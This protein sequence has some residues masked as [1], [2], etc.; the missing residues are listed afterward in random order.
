MPKDSTQPQLTPPLKIAVLV[1]G[2]LALLGLATSMAVGMVR[3]QAAAS[4]YLSGLSVWNQSQIGA[5][6]HLSRY[7]EQGLPDDL[8]RAREY[9]QVP[10]SD[11]QGRLKLEASSPEEV[12]VAEF[13]R[14]A[15]HPDDARLM[16]WL[17]RDFGD[18]GQL[19]HAFSVWRDSDPYILELDRIANDLEGYWQAAPN[20]Q[21]L[22]QLK[23]DLYTNNIMLQ[24]LASQFRQVMSNTNRWLTDTLTLA[25]LVFFIVFAILASVLIWRLV[26]LLQGTQEKFQ[27]I[28]TQA[29]VGIVHLDAAGVI[30]R[31]NPAIAD[32]L[33]IQ[34]EHLPGTQLRDFVHPEDWKI[35]QAQ[36][37][38]LAAGAL[39]RFTVEQRLNRSGGGA[40]WAR[41]TYSRASS[42]ADCVVIVEDISES[43][44]LSKELNFQ[45]THD[46]LTGLYN[47]RAFE[48]RL[49]E[50]FKRARVEG[51]SHALCFIDLDQFK[52]VN[53]T[54]GHFA[55][56]RL[57]QQVVDIFRR[58]L[59][60]CDMLARL[61][62]DEFAMVLRAARS[63]RRKKWLKNCGRR[64]R[65]SIL[66]GTG[67][68][69]TSAA[70]LGW[71]RFRALRKIPSRLCAPQTLP[72]IWLK[73]R[74][75]TGFMSRARTISFSVSAR[76]K[77]TGWAGFAKRW[78]TIACFWM[79][80]ALYL[81][82]KTP[83]C[84]LTKCWCAC[85]MKVARLFLRRLSC[86][87]RSA[88]GRPI[89]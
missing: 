42:A 55:G 52:V 2:L 80:S 45:A 68:P 41:L 81:C 5:V 46:V 60:D 43:R 79:P 6:Y 7:A 34:A 53:D 83:V 86:P 9:L 47:R 13:V 17:Y 44:R 76:V 85:A 51:A 66:V 18:L 82:S 69:I 28:F 58:E 4:A 11:R 48:R 8:Q 39:P 62:G 23:Q 40:L 72:V 73:K 59:R 25:S 67:T 22:Q 15:N 74:G 87:L 56:D 21:K 77:C 63:R 31:A 33:N 12:I 84:C 70:V 61:G 19:Q 1:A 35:E 71:W 64:W 78:K 10:L 26:R 88:L 27:A 30:T 65:S 3:L 37:R 50:S 54:S 36:G 57:L 29:A 49:G 32:I 16:I 75:A 24:R 14:G 20:P 38:Q 89:K